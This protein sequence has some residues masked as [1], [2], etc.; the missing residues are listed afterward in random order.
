MTGQK[1]KFIV[2]LFVASGIA[3][4]VVAVIYLGMSHYLEKGYYYVTYFDES[5]QGLDRDSP[6]KYRGVSIGR[7]ESISVAPDAKLIQ[8]IL[9]IE[10][11]QTLGSDVIAQLKSVGITGIMFVEMNTRKTGETAGFR[12]SPDSF[13][14]NYKVIASKP[15]DI[16][17]L[18][19]GIDNVLN[20]MKGI[21]LKGI[22][23]RIKMT[24]NKLDQTIEDAN[25][26]KISGGIETSVDRINNIL[27]KERWNKLT[28][29]L[30]DI[31]QL[32]ADAKGITASVKTSVENLK[33]IIEKE[34]WN[35]IMSSMEDAAG[36]LNTLMS[37]A[38]NV[39]ARTEGTVSS[40]DRL[41]S[42]KENT[43]KASIDEFKKALE[44]ANT[45]LTKSTFFIGNTDDSLL[46][47]KRYLLLIAQ[48]IEKASDNL[49]RLTNRL[50]DQPSQLIFGSPPPKREVEP[51]IRK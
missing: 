45:F 3:I 1:T 4:S 42:E 35:K 23:D 10:S 50:D 18:M 13:P 37:R 8:V 24:L 16:S 17:Q 38:D 33:H 15:S 43:I 29:S 40:M 11:G 22:S 20:N 28:A 39:V 46:Q 48:N 30:D 51:E 2:G 49:N 44:N 9:K 34:R 6:V 19:L 12:P 32:T 41:F 47:L 14:I 7:V 36:S 21:D 5:V 26:K 27:K 31:N 25:I